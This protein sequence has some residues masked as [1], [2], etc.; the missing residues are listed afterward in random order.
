MSRRYFLVFLFFVFTAIVYSQEEIQLDIDGQDLTQIAFID[1]SLTVSLS[2]NGGAYKP[3]GD[4]GLLKVVDITNGQVLNEQNFEKGAYL[5]N[6]GS[7]GAMISNEK[8]GAVINPFGK[9]DSGLYLK[10]KTIINTFLISKEKEKELDYYYTNLLK[11]RIVHIGPVKTGKKDVGPR[12]WIVHQMDYETETSSTIK[13]TPKEPDSQAEKTFY[14]LVQ[15]DE[16]NIYMMY[17]ELKKNNGSKKNNEQKISIVTYDYEGTIKSDITFQHTIDGEKYTFGGV[18]FKGSYKTVTS[19]G[20]PS[21]RTTSVNSLGQIFL[22]KELNTIYYM[23][24]LSG[25]KKSEGSV[26]YVAKYDLEGKKLWSNEIKFAESAISAK[27]LKYIS[28][29]PLL[30]NNRVL[31]FEDNSAFLKKFED[32]SMYSLDDNTGKVVDSKEYDRIKGI[33]KRGEAWHNT[34]SGKIFPDEL[35]KDKVLDNETILLYHF[36]EDVKK[37]LENDVI[38]NEVFYY[39]HVYNDVYYVLKA[40]FKK[41]EYNLYK[42]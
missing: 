8:S 36:N 39:S 2:S 13:F 34:V 7:S 33:Y 20:F 29:R 19:P 28:F 6:V 3:K 32:I 10:D 21:V 41:M 18:G 17:K 31:L 11:D 27:E 37:F 15:V 23:S 30:I 4:D 22:K 26:L 35:S 12:E 42:F 1:N 5:I 14:T 9:D 16:D 25:K 24:G 40:N 38:N